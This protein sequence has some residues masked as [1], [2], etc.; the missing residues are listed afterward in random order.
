MLTLRPLR[1]NRLAC[2]V[3]V[4]SAVFMAGAAYAQLPPT[5]T[6][7]GGTVQA[8]EGDFIVLDASASADQN[9]PATSLTYLWTQ[10]SGPTGESF[11][12][13]QS[14]INVIV[15]YVNDQGGILTYQ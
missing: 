6:I 14:F 9:S 11:V 5:A 7:A 12:F 4:L 13:N 1:L 2:V 3:A 8:N 15:P 10:L